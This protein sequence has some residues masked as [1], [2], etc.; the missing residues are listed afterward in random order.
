M[1]TKLVSMLLLLGLSN[2]LVAFHVGAHTDIGTRET[3]ED[4][5]V[6]NQ[7]CLAVFDG[8]TGGYRLS[9]H[10]REITEGIVQNNDLHNKGKTWE[11]L[12]L[13]VDTGQDHAKQLANK[14]YVGLANY[15]KTTWATTAAV[16]YI[17]NKN[18]LH[19]Y[20]IG[21]TR[22]VLA[23]KEGTVVYETKDHKPDRPDEK[24]R[25]VKLEQ[26][27]GWPV[28][29]IYT[30]G[31]NGKPSRVEG[32]IS[33]SRAIGYVGNTNGAILREPEFYEKDLDANDTFIINACDGLWDVFSSQEAV[34]FVRVKLEE[35]KA[36]SSE[37]DL[38]SIS[39][40]LVEAAIKKGSTDNVTVALM[41][42]SKD[43]T[44]LGEVSEIQNYNH[45]SLRNIFNP[46]CLLLAVVGALL[47]YYSR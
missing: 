25:L 46:Y 1:K 5:H 4:R 29:E 15:L 19:I 31:E 21:D 37:I 11:H 44:D 14:E 27:L 10:M 3:S 34:D 42:L 41:L 22:V 40:N 26:T 30:A 7:R 13:S 47:Y 16:A 28:G 33:I 20:Y 23:N 35:A 43:S 12:K 36:A 2:Y 17:N 18:K 8:T 38:N 24:K 45:Y 9:E 32:N 39:K 6:I